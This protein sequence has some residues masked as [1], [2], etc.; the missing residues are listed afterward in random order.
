[1]TDASVEVANL[2]ARYTE[3]IDAGDF[4]A[5]A[6]L[7]GRAAVGVGED[8]LRGRDAIRDLYVATTRRYPDGTPGTKHVISNLHL[9]IDE[10]AGT[11]AARSYWTVLQAV[12]GLPLQPIL[13]GRY[14]DRFARDG[15]G[16]YFVE[17]Q[18]L[19]DLVGDVSHHMLGGLGPARAGHP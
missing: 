14:H 10:E 3:S 12:P 11:A 1:M 6:D 4:E 9:E 15:E 2:M 18:Y 5:V 19:I 7:F 13:A 8:L 17:R 16:W